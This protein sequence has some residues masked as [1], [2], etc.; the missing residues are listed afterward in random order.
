MGRMWALVANSSFAK[1]FEIQGHG[2]YIKE[3]HHFDYPE[4]RMK[5]GEI[6]NDRPGRAFDRM[7]EGRHAL[8]TEVDVHTHEQ[9]IFAHKL[10]HVLYE[11]KVNR[12][13]DE[14][15]L[16]APP[17]FLGELKQALESQVA[18]LVS[19]E[20][21]KDLASHF[22]EKELID[23]LVKYLDLWNH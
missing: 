4:G 20:I 23:H 16:V 11:G 8:G 14:L 13:Y 10:A 17:Q 22:S 9:Q 5:S 7:G 1:I 15:A 12:L 3:I 21:P 18:K 6:L 2:K 19:K